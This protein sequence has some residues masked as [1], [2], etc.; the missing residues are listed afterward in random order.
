MNKGLKIVLIIL[1]EVVLVGGSVA[2]GS[3]FFVNN[4]SKCEN[5]NNNQSKE[6]YNSQDETDKKEEPKEEQNN[7]EETKN[8]KDNEINIEQ[9]TKEIQTTYENAY[10]L[11]SEEFEPAYTKYTTEL[12]IN[13]KKIKVYKINKERV[14]K[15]FT[16]TALEKVLNDYSGIQ[17]ND[18]YYITQEYEDGYYSD[19]FDPG[20]I[21]SS[22]DSGIRTL[23]I[24]LANDDYVLA[25]A[26]L[27]KTEYMHYGEE[28]IGFK[29]ENGTWKIAFFE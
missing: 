3:H 9:R 6:E 7:Q 8:N 21:F 10:N 20:T 15:Y 22:T 2:V 17:Q 19:T 18:N 24:L 29:K 16:S 5:Q 25:Q 12:T 14:Q 27:T 13:G 1:A 11:M 28:Y 4:N 26:E 23:K